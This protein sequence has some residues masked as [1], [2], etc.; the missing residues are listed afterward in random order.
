[1]ADK[2]YPHAGHRQRL[3]DKFSESGFLDWNEEEVLEYMLF[4][5]IPRSD[6]YDLARR[7][8]RECRT[9]KGVLEAPS[10]ILEDVEGVGKNTATYI[11][12]LNDFI[13]YLN[14]IKSNGKV[15]LT[16]S[17]MEN[18]FRETFSR[19]RRECFYMVCLDA[20]GAI[21]RKELISEGAFDATEVDVG[22][23]VRIAVC[24]EA[25]GVILAHN[26][27]GGSLEPSGVD[28]TITQV[29]RNSLKLVGVLLYDHFIV[30][31]EGVKGFIRLIERFDAEKNIQKYSSKP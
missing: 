20:R 24:A 7:L 3:R 19:H 26:H 18:Y 6:T 16:R 2:K 21:I 5:A 14:G 1:M 28:L 22:R 25:A 17:N 30:T 23:V 29:L 12:S 15:Y 9:I 8:I 31:D 13:G 11:K 27:P 10:N 4:Y